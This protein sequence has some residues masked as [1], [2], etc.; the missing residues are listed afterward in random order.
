MLDK[1]LKVKEI[2]DLGAR[3]YL[4][5][6]ISPE[7]A[8][9]TRP[10]QFVM[11]KCSGDVQDLPLL[12]RPFSVFDIRN[13][14][15]TGKP[16]GLDIL[17]K[18]VGA[19]TRRLAEARPGDEVHVLG[20]QGVPFRIPG[21]MQDR[22]HTACLVAGGV[23]IA[24]LLLLARELISLQIT[25][26][27][28]YGGRHLADLVLREH[29]EQLGIETF[30]TTEDGSYGERGLVTLPLERLIKARSRVG[31]HIYACGPWSMMK[32]CHEVSVR[33]GV[34]CEVSL[35]ARM[36]CSLGAC[37]GCVVHAWDQRGEDQYLRVCLE[38]PVMP[39][40]IV[41]WNTPPL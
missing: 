13:N 25:P 41:D 2:R 24:A 32:A 23:G 3:N 30:Y 28:F 34:P 35:E 33:H 21:S 17:V 9:L 11:V 6:L 18:N 31:V 36:G 29:F 39:S 20:P 27:L 7:Q 5:T 4:L 14:P 40:G 1:K 12:R 10:G 22:K 37:M 19:G 8:R 38:G 26:L 15:R 16:A